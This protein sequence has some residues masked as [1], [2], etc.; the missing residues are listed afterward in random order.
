MSKYAK[1][2]IT[3]LDRRNM[4]INTQIAHNMKIMTFILNLFT[5]LE[6]FTHFFLTFIFQKQFGLSGGMQIYLRQDI[7]KLFKPAVQTV[8]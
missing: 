1:I 2:A 8:G 5:F 7:L 3:S 4:V 6:I